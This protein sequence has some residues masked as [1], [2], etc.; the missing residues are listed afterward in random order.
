MTESAAPKP[1]LADRIR[2]KELGVAEYIKICL[3]PGEPRGKTYEVLLVLPCPGADERPWLRLFEKLG[4]AGSTVIATPNFPSAKALIETGELA[5]ILH[6]DGDL[7]KKQYALDE[8]F[9]R[10]AA[11]GIRA[12]PLFLFADPVHVEWAEQTLRGFLEQHCPIS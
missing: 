9:A 6:H 7:F 2:A 4:Y 10:T 5:A 3:V 8:V 12:V 11:K 1:S